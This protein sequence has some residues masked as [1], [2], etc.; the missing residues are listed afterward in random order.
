VG[1]IDTSSGG[2]Y[3]SFTQGD[4]RNLMT[5]V[6]M[7]LLSK[8]GFLDMLPAT[9]NKVDYSTFLIEQKIID[10]PIDSRFEILDL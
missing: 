7:G 10:E 5:L 1:L 2:S 4:L 3:S 6:E 9:I 8:Q